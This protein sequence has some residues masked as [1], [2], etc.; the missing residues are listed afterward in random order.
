[1]TISLL[2]NEKLNCLRSQLISEL[3]SLLTNDQKNFIL[4]FKNRRPEWEISGIEGIENYPSV[5]WKL[6][7]LKRMDNK[8]H[9]AAYNKL[10]DYLMACEI[11]S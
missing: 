8:K 6:M 11:E 5:K 7:N 2:L 10:K 1:M 4:S 3:K 9:Q